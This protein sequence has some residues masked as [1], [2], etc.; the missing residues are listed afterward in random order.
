MV[1]TLT[2]IKHRLL[3]DDQVFA[4]Q[5]FLRRAGYL[6]LRY[7][8]DEANAVGGTVIPAGSITLAHYI[9]L[10]TSVWWEMYLPDGSPLA[11]LIHLTSPVRIGESEVEYTDLLLD[12]WQLA[13]DEPRLLDEDEL[14][15]AVSSAHLDEATADA[16]LRQAHD[17]IAEMPAHAPPLWH[18]LDPSPEHLEARLSRL[19][20]LLVV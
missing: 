16:L 14:R 15:E 4:C 2:E 18:Q 7:V 8:N 3:K 20:L 19:S 12:I 13:E 11:D 10:H 1:E 17:I 5:V 9:H 6:V